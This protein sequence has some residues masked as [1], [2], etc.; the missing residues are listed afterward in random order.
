MMHADKQTPWLVQPRDQ[1]F[2]I[3]NLS[4]QTKNIPR[5]RKNAY[6]TQKTTGAEDFELK[7]LLWLPETDPEYWV[8][9]I[10]VKEPEAFKKNSAQNPRYFK[11]R[12]S[13]EQLD[14]AKKAEKPRKDPE[15]NQLNVFQ[16]SPTKKRTKKYT[17]TLKKLGK[18]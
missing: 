1:N 17:G 11:D 3:R 2:L 6:Y 13:G 8:A 16:Y 14:K 7:V 15:N 10:A 18:I 4:S 5:R 9:H 12:S